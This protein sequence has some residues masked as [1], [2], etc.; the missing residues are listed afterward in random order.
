MEDSHVLVNSAAHELVVSE[1]VMRLLL[2]SSLPVE[3]PGSKCRKGSLADVFT[4]INCCLRLFLHFF[5][6]FFF[7]NVEALPLVGHSVVPFLLPAVEL[8]AGH[9]ITMGSEK[10]VL[11]DQLSLATLA[12]RGVFDHKSLDILVLGEHSAEELHLCQLV[13]RL[14]R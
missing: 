14:A 12:Q 3:D 4:V 9:D 6:C 13:K 10:V 1:L 7:D 8:V 11:L 2:S 5:Y